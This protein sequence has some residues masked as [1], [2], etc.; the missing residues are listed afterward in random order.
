MPDT[1]SSGT[2]SL[3]PEHGARKRHYDD[4]LEPPAMG[5]ANR[6]QPDSPGDTVINEEGTWEKVLDMKSLHAPGHK[7]LCRQN[8]GNE[9]NHLM[10]NQ[11]GSTIPAKRRRVDTCDCSL[12][13]VIQWVQDVATEACT[14]YV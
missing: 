4:L 13:P 6:D 7:R 12:P 1:I 14:P 11:M 9:G 3:P 10:Q 8:Y 5:T 2:T